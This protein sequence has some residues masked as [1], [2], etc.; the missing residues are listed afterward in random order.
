MVL[1][2]EGVSA[3]DFLNE[4]SQCT[5]LKNMDVKAEMVTPYCYNSNF[6]EELCAV[7]LT[8]QQK[9]TLEKRKQVVCTYLR[10]YVCLI[11]KFKIVC[12]TRF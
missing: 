10:L 3:Y 1:V 9:K 5:M 2:V 7:P 11:I 4:E 12:A 6:V 8:R